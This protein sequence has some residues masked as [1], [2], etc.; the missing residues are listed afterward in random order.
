MLIVPTAAFPPAA[1]S[2][3]QVTLFVGSRVAV[4]LNCT[5]WVTATTAARTGLMFTAMTWAPASLP[6]PHPPIPRVVIKQAKAHAI[7]GEHR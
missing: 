1:P 6:E 4:A 7:R 3:L 2:T 5:D